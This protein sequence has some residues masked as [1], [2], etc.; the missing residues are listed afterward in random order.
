[1]F[2][3]KDQSC[4]EVRLANA[5]QHF[6]LIATNLHLNDNLILKDITSWT[7]H[8]INES[9]TYTLSKLDMS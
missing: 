3:G 7:R 1:M 2:K 8:D 6:K 9:D 5:I 4:L